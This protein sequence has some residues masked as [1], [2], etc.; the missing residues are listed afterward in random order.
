[1]LKN[2]IPRA[3]IETAIEMFQR[4]EA[5]NQARRGE[6]AGPLLSCCDRISLTAW[7]VILSL[8]I[9]ELLLLRTGCNTCRPVSNAVFYTIHL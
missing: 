6:T 2:T 9:Y 4:L 7:T 3:R 5:T 8:F 1:M